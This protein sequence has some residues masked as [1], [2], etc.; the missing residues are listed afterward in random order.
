METAAHLHRPSTSEPVTIDWP[1]VAGQASVHLLALLALFPPFFTWE[2]VVIALLGHYF[3][4]T[5][6]IGLG[7]HRLLTH[8][9][10]KCSKWLEYVFATLGVFSMQYA[11]ARWVAVHR[12]HH[13]DCETE[14]DP[15]SPL[16]GFFWG[17][18]GWILV[19]NRSH[20]DQ[21]SYAPVVGDLLK[22]R[23]YRLL[24]S[25]FFV[26]ATF[27]LSMVFFAG[28]GYAIGWA[29]TGTTDGALRMAA[30]IVLWGVFVRT[31]T[32]WHATWSVN[33]IA[34][35]F[36]YRWYDTPDNSRNNWFVAI[37]ATG[38]GWHNNHH[39]DPVSAKHGHAWWEVDVTWISIW[40]LEK[41][42]L[43]WDVKRP[44]LT[45]PST[46]LPG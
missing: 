37:V 15:H 25:W 33:S 26:A 31:V 7:Y 38:E 9:G 1:N 40:V 43:V 5:L 8:R 13:R 22:D 10:L 17:H 46:P 20:E 18:I 30:S 2:G 42:G 23:Y 16:A 24:E 45:R 34:H 35:L 4:G 3:V 39:A 32:V 11:P 44:R 29:Q 36:G 21:E 28:L 14:P 12:M 6:G 41:L 19:V 27:V